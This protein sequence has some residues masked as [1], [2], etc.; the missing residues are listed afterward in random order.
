MHRRH[1]RNE[2]QQ[3]VL[4][5]LAFAAAP[6]PEDN[7]AALRE[8]DRLLNLVAMNMP[9]WQ[10]LIRLQRLLGAAYFR[11]GGRAGRLLA[12]IMQQANAIPFAETEALLD[13]LTALLARVGLAFTLVIALVITAVTAAFSRLALALSPPL[14]EIGRASCRE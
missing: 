4:Q 9:E 7:V 6:A 3:A 10:S 11:S 14:D 1:Q 2:R 13:A 12:G 8:A 5:A